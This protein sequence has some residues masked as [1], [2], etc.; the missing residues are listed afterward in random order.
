MDWFEQL[1]GLASDDPATVRA[2]ISLQAEALVLKSDGRKLRFGKLWMPQ[3][4]ELPLPDVGSG[5]Q[6]KLREVVADVQAL[7]RDPA[8]EQAV[9]QVAS[10]FNLLEM[11]GPSVTPEQGI[12]R[13]ATD[14]TQGPACAIACAAGTIYRNY[15]VPVQGQIG[16]TAQVQL[17][18]LA[19]FGARIGNA[20]AQLWQMRNGYV[21]PQRGGLA[22]IAG[23]IG[24]NPEAGDLIRV[25]V[26]SDTEVTLAGASHCVTQVYCS[27]LPIAY[28]QDD[29]S[30]WAPFAQM[31]LQ[32]A[33]AATLAVAW[34]NARRTGQRRLYLTR[35][36][37]GAFGNPAG[38]ITKA[39]HAA[40]TRFD[41][42][43]LEVA[44]VSYGRE[45]PDNRALL[46]AFGA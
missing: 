35:L 28:G 8:N 3:L 12:A 36:G 27:A 45:D 14:R 4:A 13:Y 17:D 16:Q 30:D 46:R 7:H 32:A 24:Q 9:F 39:I 10:Q 11:I 29:V 20:Q 5:R 22:K 31:V 21:M 23:W 34:Q 43:D 41:G 26:Q 1:T 15:F 2:G 44:L 33:Y 37:G 25:G 6:I 38:W 40:L 19:D 42:C 18:M